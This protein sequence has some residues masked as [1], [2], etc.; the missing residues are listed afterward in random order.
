MNP[1]P[2]IIIILPLIFLLLFSCREVYYPEGLNGGKA[3]PIIKGQIIE[4]GSPTV[5]MSRA[6][7]YGSSVP[8]YIRGALVRVTDDQGNE[9]TLTESDPGHYVD[10]MG[11]MYGTI[12]NAYQLHVKMADGEEFESSMVTMPEKPFADSLYADPGNPRGACV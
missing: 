11:E 5:V 3:I 1:K 8:E 10:A 7:D 9:V 4:D 2:H 12:G 6:M